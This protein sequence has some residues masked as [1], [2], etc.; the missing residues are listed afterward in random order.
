MLGVGAAHIARGVEVL[1]P[2]QVQLFDVVVVGRLRALVAREPH[3]QLVKAQV[4]LVVTAAVFLLAGL[5]H[6]L[7]QGFERLLVGFAEVLVRMLGAKAEHERAQLI[8]LEHFA[9]RE[10]AHEHAA[11]DHRRHQAQ[12]AEDADR[13]AHRPTARAHAQRQRRFIEALAG[14]QLA[15]VDPLLELLGHPAGQVLLGFV[16]RGGHGWRGSDIG[17]REWPNGTAWAL[18]H[19]QHPHFFVNNFHK[20][21][22]L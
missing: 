18:L 14:L 16:G 5:V 7:Q 20:V 10:L 8:G 2:K 11:V 9:Q 4:E 19:A 12:T 17:G 21:L 1:A 22:T 6:A 3:D 13:F 15:R